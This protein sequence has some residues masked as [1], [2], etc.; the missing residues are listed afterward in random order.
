M[1]EF[2]WL[3]KFI[4]TYTE[5]LRPEYRENMKYLARANLDFAQGKFEKALENISKVKYDIFIY[6]FDVKNLMLKIYYEL[7]LF[8]PAFS[9]IDAFKHFLS[10]NKEHAEIYRMQYGNFLRIYGKL[11]KAK[12]S[13]KTG[14]V[15]FLSEEVDSTEALASRIWLK[16]KINEF[17]N[18]K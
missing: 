3:K 5:K 2:R 8:D 10:E 9:L 12:E 16:E 14:E 17:V 7:N 13:G 15:D 6:K 1:K 11:L 18:G 4:E